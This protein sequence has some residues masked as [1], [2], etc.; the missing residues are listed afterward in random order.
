MYNA[1]ER[2]VNTQEN[3]VKLTGEERVKWVEEGCKCTE[4]G[5]KAVRGGV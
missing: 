3:G 2:T 4:E 5:C 1:Q